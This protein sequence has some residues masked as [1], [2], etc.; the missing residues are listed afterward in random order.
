[1]I[2]EACIRKYEERFS[3]SDKN[4]LGSCYKRHAFSWFIFQI[5][6]G[7]V[8]K[9]NIDEVVWSCIEISRSKSYY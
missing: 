1:M 8:F 7:S 4:I 2:I 5:T 9:N 6:Y 3:W